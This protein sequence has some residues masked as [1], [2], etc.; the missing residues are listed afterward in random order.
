MRATR[1]KL[2]GKKDAE[3]RS[4]FTVVLRMESAGWRITGWARKAPIARPF[5]VD[6][7]RPQALS[8]YPATPSLSGP[9]FLARRESDDAERTARA[10]LDLE[11]HR[12]DH[13]T[14]NR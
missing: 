11:R 3:I 12:H 13:G 1:F 2:N 9:S 5:G 6:R 10:T 4:L 8:T 14:E 7:A